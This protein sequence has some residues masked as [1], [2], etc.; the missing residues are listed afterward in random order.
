MAGYGLQEIPGV[1]R[2]GKR[3]FS[4]GSGKLHYVSTFVSLKHN[5]TREIL[6]GPYVGKAVCKGDS[7]GPMFKV[8]KFGNK[9]QLVQVGIASRSDCVSEGAH[10]NVFHYLDW[11][12]SIISE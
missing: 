1:S 6:T 11:I 9:K 4:G 5:V 7:G 2:L 12:E 10:T 3:V 8:E